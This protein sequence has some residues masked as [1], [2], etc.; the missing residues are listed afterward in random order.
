[1]HHTRPSD[2]EL[3]KRLFEAKEALK[4]QDG[5][6]ANQS[7]AVSEL[8]NLEVGD[9]NDL[10][11]LIRELLEEISPKDYKGTRPPQKSYEKA[12]YG[13]E[14]FAFTWWS[15]KYNKQMYIKFALKKGRYYYVSLH[16]SRSSDQKGED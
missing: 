5:F 15:P 1:M 7:K 8:Y 13:L 9:T 4:S 16:E 14:L 10:W 2:K 12:I 6:F 3:N 11:P